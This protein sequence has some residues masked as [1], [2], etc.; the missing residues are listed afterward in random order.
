MSARGISCITRVFLVDFLPPTYP[1][2]PFRTSYSTTLRLQIPFFIYSGPDPPPA[3][4]GSPGD[5]YVAPA[6]NALYACMAVAG[7]DGGGGAGSGV[8]TPWC[9]I[10]YSEPKLRAFKLSEPGLLLHPYF[11]AHVLW[12]FKA[13]FGWYSLVTLN[14]LRCDS[15]LKIL[16]KGHEEAGEAAKVLVAQ[17][18]QL[19]QEKAILAADR[20][21]EKGKKKGAKR[22]ASAV[23]NEEEEEGEREDEEDDYEPKK[24]KARE[25][26]NAVV[27]NKLS[28]A[29][30]ARRAR[31]RLERANR[32]LPPS[33]SHSVSVG[34]TSAYQQQSSVPTPAPAPA[35]ESAATAPHASGNDWD[36]YYGRP[37]GNTRT[38]KELRELAAVIAR[39]EA[40]NAVLKG[41]VAEH[42]TLKMAVEKLKR[43]NEALKA[44]L[45]GE[46]GGSTVSM[47]VAP[48][49][50]GEAEGGGM[51]QERIPFH[52]EFL[53]FMR[54]TFASEMMKSCNSQR[55]AAETSAADAKLQVAAL[56]SK[57][58][59][60]DDAM[61]LED[62]TSATSDELRIAHARAE[63]RR[64]A[65]RP[66]Q[67]G[68][69]VATTIRELEDQIKEQK[70]EIDR[71]TAALDI[72]TIC[73]SDQ[74]K[75]ILTSKGEVARLTRS[76]DEE[77]DL[78]KRLLAARESAKEKEG[79]GHVQ[80][81][82]SFAIFLWRSIKISTAGKD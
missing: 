35:S 48:V 23:E 72:A 4:L 62:D 56:Q 77:T 39:L 59:Q 2:L 34:T 50:R 65:L 38:G 14:N 55:V 31:E 29:Q 7:A 26:A 20:K 5:L 73:I 60:S 61:E 9:A 19:Q 74:Q 22:R 58:T 46:G 18:L 21:G 17:T 71:V 47:S 63:D 12:T 33:A 49:Q 27:P 53:D 54:E 28:I 11:P 80:E 25:E 24:K 64:D 76:A 3:E 42:W 30:Q 44:K 8:W 15:Q 32:A 6:T 78:L 41:E 37:R 36:A 66:G 40:E 51:R 69:T 82:P 16:V 79:Q 70:A 13:N 1:F 81:P 43:E 52:P 67:L 45:E 75:E 57:L 68:I 10:G